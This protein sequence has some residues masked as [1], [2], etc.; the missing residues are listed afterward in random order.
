MKFINKLAYYCAN[1]LMKQ[2]KEDH[3]RRRIYYYGFIVVFGAILKGI[4]IISVSFLLGVLLTTL[5]IVALFGSARSILG[6]THLDKYWKCILTSL[7]FFLLISMVSKYTYSYWNG[8]SVVVFVLIAFTISFIGIL[9]W[10]PSDSPNRPITNKDE[11]RKFRLFSIVYSLVWVILAI[12]ASL[13][14]LIGKLPSSSKQYIIAACFTLLLAV[15]VIS[16]L[17]YKFFAKISGKKI[18]AI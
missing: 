1:L 11:I 14:Y 12:S 10:A 8:I 18:R 13:L 4:L 15:F 2:L 9:K 17:G 3:E 5:F 16:P 7:S 6:G